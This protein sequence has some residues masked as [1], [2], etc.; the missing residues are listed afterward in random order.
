[1]AVEMLILSFP[2]PG[3]EPLVLDRK[4]FEVG[5]DPGW[6]VFFDFAEAVTAPATADWAM[7]PVPRRRLGPSHAGGE[8]LVNQQPVAGWTVP[9]V[10]PATWC[11]ISS[12]AGA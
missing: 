4:E 1:M 12:E 5:S 6:E 11:R 3:A 2:R 7:S 9:F 8:V 10:F